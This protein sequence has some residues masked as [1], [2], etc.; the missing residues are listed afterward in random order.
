MA[1]KLHDLILYLHAFL[2]CTQTHA[3]DYEVIYNDLLYIR[4]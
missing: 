2:R 4:V 1:K 3:G